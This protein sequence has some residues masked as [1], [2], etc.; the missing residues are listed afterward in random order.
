LCSARQIVQLW[1]APMSRVTRRSKAD[2]L[3]KL[4]PA[5]VPQRSAHDFSFVF[6][7]HDT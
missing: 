4:I 1:Q 3:P 2:T 6:L 7:F 5:F